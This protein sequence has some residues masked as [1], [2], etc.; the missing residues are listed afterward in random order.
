MGALPGY[1][2]A[3]APDEIYVNLFIGSQAQIN[4]S[5]NK[6]TLRQ[7][8]RYPWDGSVQLA[9][10]P[11]RDAEFAVNLRL[12]AWSSEPTVT[13]NGESVVPIET[14]RGYARLHRKW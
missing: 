8:T 12:P 1:I 10:N 2:Y 6:V 3:Q 14:V 4:V 5:G 11:E 9:I 13:V 7:T